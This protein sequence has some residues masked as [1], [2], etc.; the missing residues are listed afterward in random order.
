MSTYKEIMSLA[1]AMGE[2]STLSKRREAGNRLAERLSLA[3][4]R[5]QLVTEAGVDP[6][7]AMCEL[8]R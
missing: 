1:R 2:E 7:K 5:Q 8:W 3:R 6:F 4:V